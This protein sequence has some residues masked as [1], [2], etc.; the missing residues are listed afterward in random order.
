MPSAIIRIAPAVM[1]KQFE[2]I[3]AGLGLSSSK[4]SVIA[5]IFMENSLDGVYSHG[6]N[7]FP[8][9]VQYIRDG[10]I[11]IHGEA[12]SRHRRGVVEQWEGNSGPGILNALRCSERA[13]E[14]ARDHGIG[15]VAL[16]HTNHWM[17]GGT[18]G[19]QVARAGY[20]YIGW[21]NTIA[22][23]PP[24]GATD[25][26]LGNNPLVI[27]VPYQDEAIVL[28]M[29]MSQFSFGALEQKKMRNE[30]LPV[31]GGYNM[32]GEL[33]Y[34]AAEILETQRALPAGFWKGSG[35]SLLLDILATILS[36][37]LSVKGVTDQGAEYNLSQVFIAVALDGLKN[38][39]RISEAIEEIIFDYHRAS[40]VEGPGPVLYP[41]ERVLLTRKENQANGIPVMTTVWSEIMSMA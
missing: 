2:K 17:R 28:D 11:N 1:L 25:P 41:G 31:P 15:C 34:D 40:R 5:R 7:R 8:K 22:N 13:M 6:V 4:A 9:F 23:M 37:G 21:T 33:S 30:K 12:E 10:H 35:L 32:E 27:A 26:R 18:Y 3:L 20:A 36:D 39:A 38:Y 29:A 24:W 16:A 14:I 19:W